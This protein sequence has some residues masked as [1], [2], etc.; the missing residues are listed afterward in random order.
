MGKK[1]KSYCP[2]R[3]HQDQ[4]RDHLQDIDEDQRGDT[5]ER[6][7]EADTADLAESHTEEEEVTPRLHLVATHPPR[8]QKV[9]RIIQDVHHEKFHVKDIPA[10]GRLAE[11]VT[12]HQD[13]DQSPILR[14]Y[15]E[16][17]ALEA[18][19][20][21]LDSVIH[22]LGQLLQ[23]IVMWITSAGITDHQNRTRNVL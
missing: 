18:V 3:L 22:Q 4:Y 12:H 9:G 19:V 16:K 7:V 15:Q 17:A 23:L 20:D 2:L 8:H 10:A 11:V 1:K 5:A 14:L 21:L 13:R 6:E